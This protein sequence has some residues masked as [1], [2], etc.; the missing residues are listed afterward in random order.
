MKQ[1]NVAIAVI[2]QAGRVLICQRRKNDAFGDLWEFPG[3][4][5]EPGETPEKC[6]VREI[7]EELGISI[8]PM[9]SF[10]I[11][12]HTYPDFA[13]RLFP[14]LGT[15][16]AGDPRPLASQRLQWVQADRLHEY[17]FPAASV[18]LIDQIITRLSQPAAD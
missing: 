5:I 13:V 7:D 1:I 15:L 4:K 9:A 3:G 10:P 11:I 6:L 16:V 12:N 2:H 18:G 14:F 8:K 17:P